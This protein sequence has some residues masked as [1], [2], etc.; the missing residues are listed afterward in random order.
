MTAFGLSS[1]W[2]EQAEISQKRTFGIGRWDY[3]I[4][5]WMATSQGALGTR[6]EDVEVIKVNE[7]YRVNDA[8]I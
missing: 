3:Q 4:K 6:T 8:R 2:V 5:Y 7:E 1:P